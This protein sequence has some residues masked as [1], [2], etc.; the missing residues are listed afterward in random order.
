MALL[1]RGK[2]APD[3]LPSTSATAGPTRQ[4]RRR[5]KQ[6]AVA[7]GQRG[8]AVAGADAVAVAGAERSG[9]GECLGQ[10]FLTRSSLGEGNLAEANRRAQPALLRPFGQAAEPGSHSQA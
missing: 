6:E 3:G 9:K 7:S 4:N 10:A 5:Q 2:D 1:A 8:A